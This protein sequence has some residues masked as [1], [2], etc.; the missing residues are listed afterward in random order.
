MQTQKCEFNAL[1]TATTIEAETLTT[2]KASRSH[3]SR[4]SYVMWKTES[5]TERRYIVVRRSEQ[6]FKL[7]IRSRK[8]HEEEKPNPDSTLDF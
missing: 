1:A 7:G 3:L 2:L 6:S 4:S 5:L 8:K